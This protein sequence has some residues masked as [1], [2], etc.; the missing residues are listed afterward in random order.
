MR[1]DEFGV[2]ANPK[3]IRATAISFKILAGVSST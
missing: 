1:T 3:S 2:Q